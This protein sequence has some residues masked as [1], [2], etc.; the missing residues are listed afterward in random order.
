VTLSRLWPTLATLY[1][2]DDGTV[3]MRSWTEDDTET[4]LPNLVF[5]RQNGVPL[6]ENGVPGDRVT[7][8]GGGNWSGSGDA[9]LRTLRGGACMR[10]IEGTQFLIYAY[11][12]TATPSGMAR[13]FQA[14]G[15]EYAMLLD[16]NSQEHT[17]MALYVQD[18]DTLDT[19]HLVRAMEEIDERGSDGARI[20][21]FVSTADNRDFFYLLRRE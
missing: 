17:Y 14:Y 2:L 9:D 20:P 13:T 19:Q 6:I 11:F 16:M 7:S 8:W 4:L 3:G 18:E 15:C 12:S 10:T 5:A 21:R 1:M